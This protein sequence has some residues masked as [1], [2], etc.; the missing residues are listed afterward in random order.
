MKKTMALILALVLV[1]CFGASS[2]MAA[3]KLNTAQENF[4]F[5]TSYWN[6]GYAFAKVENVGD[7]PIN[8]NAGVLELYDADG[9]VLNSSDYLYAYAETLQPG[10]YT[11]IEMY[12]EVEDETAVAEDYLLTLTGKSDNDCTTLRLPVE[13][14]LEM[15]VEQGYWTYNYMYAAVTNNTEE[16]IYNL[17]VVLALLDAD[18]NILYIDS[19]ALYSER[20]LAPGSSMI[21]RMDIESAFIEYFAANNITPASVDAI[22]YVNIDNY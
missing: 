20:A 2:A 12:S 16:P 3:G 22:A 13:T 8:V 6:Y 10:E 14:K 18:G 5:V 9:N 17:E 21:F 1:M 19:D 15:N 4:H 11:Y 7:K